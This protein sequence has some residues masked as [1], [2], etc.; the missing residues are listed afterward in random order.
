MQVDMIK[1]G[2][3]HFYTKAQAL[4]HEKKYKAYGTRVKYM[5]YKEC[6]S[7]VLLV[8]FPAFDP[9]TAKY[10]YMRTLSSFKC[11]KLFLLDDFGSNHRGCYMVENNVELCTRDLIVSK[12]DWC[13][14]QLGGG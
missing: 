13:I 14:K 4:L 10:N 7:N 12:I 6:Q 9:K 3:N 8:S 5:F 11:N 1:R 2:V